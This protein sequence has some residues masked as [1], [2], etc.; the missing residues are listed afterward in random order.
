MEINEMPRSIESEAA[1][2]GSVLINAEI[3]DDC[4][5][6][7]G[8]DDFSAI[9][10]KAIW[11]AFLELHNKKRDIDMLTVSE[12]VK[13]DGVEFSYLTGLVGMSPNSYNAKS[14]AEEVRDK[15]RRRRQV[16]IAERIIK[17][18]F[19]GGVNVADIVGDLVGTSDLRRSG[20]K[21]TKGLSEYYD[22]VSERYNDPREVWGIN[23][24]YSEL[25]KSTGGLHKG[26]VVMISGAPGAGKSILASAIILKSAIQGTSWAVYSLEMDK[27]DL[28]N[29]WVGML[30][31][32]SE[33]KLSSGTFDES[34]WPLITNAI[35]TL[36]SLPIYINDMPAMTTTDISADISRMQTTCTIDAVCVDYLE[37]LGDTADTSNDATAKKSRRFR[38]I[39]RDK[40]LAGL[41]IQSMTKEGIGAATGGIAQG[42]SKKS[43]VSSQSAIIGV[44][45]PAD[46]GH[47]ADTIFMLVIDPEDSTGRTIAALPVKKRHG[48][49]SK[50]P[51]RF[52]WHESAPLLVQADK[53]IYFNSRKDIE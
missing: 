39:C 14:Y 19:N 47:D 1:V 50:K 43:F 32:L 12:L 36:E 10:N 8:A 52:Q 21:L 45:G 5:H 30:T 6:I 38:E 34:K 24:G 51:I 35:E 53:E 41:I 42:N 37:L 48:S 7:I 9:S 28:I 26:H 49:G 27:A 23:T 15:S 16:Q 46:V 22:Y 20:E 11:K 29:R 25:D 31:G 4:S 40:K 44:R 3:F 17:G 13:H 2:I 33:D 18:A